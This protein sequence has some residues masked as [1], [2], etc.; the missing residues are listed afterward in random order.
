MTHGQTVRQ[1]W[2]VQ[3]KI[4]SH[5]KS[6]VLQKQTKRN[7]KEVLCLC[8]FFFLLPEKLFSWLSYLKV[9]L[10]SF[11]L[12]GHARHYIIHLSRFETSAAVRM[13]QNAVSLISP[14]PTAV[15]RPSGR[16]ASSAS[17]SLGLFQEFTMR[18]GRNSM[19][20]RVWNGRGRETRGGLCLTCLR[21]C[22]GSRPPR[23][24]SCSC[25]CAGRTVMMSCLRLECLSV[26]GH[27]R[28]SFLP[29]YSPASLSWICSLSA[30][31]LCGFSS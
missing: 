22:P 27:S 30:P 21:S 16:K 8:G 12:K 31:R 15:D 28:T 26:P 4:K 19:R 29:F 13:T 18:N 7:K 10:S 24:E 1:Q 25:R 2:G 11:V 17:E 3:L 5:L 23:C 14:T 20:W 9:D 6:K